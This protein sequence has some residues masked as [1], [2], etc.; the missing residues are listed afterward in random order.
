MMEINNRDVTTWALP[1]GAIAR[2]DRGKVKDVAFSPDGMHLAVATDIGL[3]WYEL[4]T[5]QPGALWETERGMVSAVS[6]SHD[7]Q[8]IATGNADGIVKVWNTQDQQCIMEVGERR[9]IN[10]S[11]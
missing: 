5:M 11:P 9:V 3:W 1:E 6:F 10:R 2:L 8:W 7:G 4:S